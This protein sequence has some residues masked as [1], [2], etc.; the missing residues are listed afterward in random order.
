[1]YQSMPIT[2]HP[3]LS[4]SACLASISHHTGSISS[5]LSSIYDTLGSIYNCIGH[6]Y[7]YKVHIYASRSS[8]IHVSGSISTYLPFVCSRLCSMS[9]AISIVCI[10]LKSISSHRGSLPTV[11][12]PY[13]HSYMHA[14][15]PLSTCP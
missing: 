12:G 5:C 8:Y 2:T 15:G 10:L 14:Y 7:M 11:Y 4:I 6:I 13:I 1:M 9:I 3:L